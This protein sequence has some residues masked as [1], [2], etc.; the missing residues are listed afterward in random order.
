MHLSPGGAGGGLVVEFIPT[1]VP[2][3]RTTPTDHIAL[4]SQGYTPFGPWTVFSGSL[5]RPV[6]AKNTEVRRFL[7]RRF[8]LPLSHSQL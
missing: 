4:S 1:S 6:G 3:S 5:V 7:S 2:V 8:H